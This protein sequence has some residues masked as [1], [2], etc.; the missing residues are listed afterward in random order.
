MALSKVSGV[1][2]VHLFSCLSLLP[3][4][5]LWWFN[6]MF[7]SLDLPAISHSILDGVNCSSNAQS[8]AF[9]PCQFLTI[10]RWWYLTDRERSHDSLCILRS[11]GEDLSWYLL[12]E[13][14]QYWLKTR[15]ETPSLNCPIER[16]TYMATV[17]V[18]YGAV[19]NV[20]KTYYGFM[21]TRPLIT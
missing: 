13:V 2:P 1:F 16:L 21:K 7:Y 17:R 12:S 10:S 8:T 15:A 11:G 19:L 20:E 18:S 9:A 4:L 3:S 6:S 5:A 14:I